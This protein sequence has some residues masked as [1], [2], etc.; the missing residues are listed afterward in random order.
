MPLRPISVLIATLDRK[1]RLRRTVAGVLGQSAL[2]CEIVI[3][4]ASAR[5]LTPADL[6]SAPEGV[7]VRCLRADRRGAAAQR[8][9]AQTA[10]SQPFVLFLDDDV[11]L[12]DGCLEALWGG[13]EA[14]PDC[15]GCGAI[16]VNQ[17]YSPPGVVM[18][19]LFALLGCPA[20]GSLA[21]RCAGPAL[22]FLPDPQAASPTV[23]W[24]NLGCV[25]YRR[26]AL[27]VPAFL[28]FFH[29]YSLME[30][31]AL[32]LHVGRRWRL[33][34]PPGAR[35]FHDSRPAGYKDRRFAR[36]RM[37][38]VNRWFVMRAIM[39][40]DGL[41]WDLRQLAV[42][43][44]MLLVPLRRPAGWLGF[45]AA[46]AGKISGLCTV[47]LQGPRWRGYDPLPPP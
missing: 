2:P 44:L 31:A 43:V 34:A 46:L 7:E 18:R 16:M 14:D 12:H 4:D 8:N 23:E 25:L 33:L 26:A 36:E 39:G 5:P 47:A 28:P 10:S 13:M 37:E 32:A 41:A 22:N 3:V 19:R 35:G 40:R 30:D 9:Q 11:D 20:A 24:L 6:P 27:P 21:G 15:G 38:I 17:H 42:Q 1:E 29:G 45:P